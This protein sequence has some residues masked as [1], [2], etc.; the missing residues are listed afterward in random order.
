LTKTFKNLASSAIQSSNTSSIQ[1]SSGYV[2]LGVGCGQF[3]ALSTGT[4]LAPA[5]E[6]SPLDG[7][8]I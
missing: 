4:H 2:A 5:R 1:M 7:K 6:F 3:V 8:T